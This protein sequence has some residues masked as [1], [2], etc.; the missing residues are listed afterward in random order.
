M[1]R[2]D[3]D[4]KIGM[5][6]IDE[7]WAKFEREVIGQEAEPKKRSLVPWAWGIGIAA[8]IALVAGIFLW[9]NDAEVPTGNAAVL[10]QETNVN[11]PS[12]GDAADGDGNGENTNDRSQIDNASSSDIKDNP[13]NNL[14]AMAS[15][16]PASNAK[17]QAPTTGKG[18]E[19]KDFTTAGQQPSFHGD[20]SA[21][22]GRI[23]GL[24]VVSDSSDL[25][26]STLLV[27]GT[28][29]RNA[30]DSALFL[31][32]G[33]V[34]SASFLDEIMQGRHQRVIESIMI[35][36]D[37][38]AKQRYL[39]KYGERVKYGVVVVTTA[40]DT[41]CEAYV[42]QHPEVQQSRRH[43]TGYVV[44]GKTNKPLAN[45][46]INLSRRGFSSIKTDSTGHFAF[47]PPLTA[48]TLWAYGNGYKTRRFHPA[49]TV[50]NI[51]LE[52]S[53]TLKDVYDAHR[54]DEKKTIPAKKIIVRGKEIPGVDE[55]MLEGK[56]K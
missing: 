54:S 7:E 32:D 42:S 16:S 27:R 48:D 3:I 40:P 37:E 29:A 41:L 21:L 23:A 17:E 56:I 6:D 34:Q 33:M 36:K 50:L 35:Y 22:Q 52:P 9:G 43:V 26:K 5:P 51:R 19:V 28:N 10:A 20:D 45:V 39:E 4:K 11:A 13:T 53:R 49:D 15:T 38:D 14:L 1:K 18:T 44:D 31:V 47:W 24:D 8:S 12:E 25:M 55:E 46:Q 2:E 30:N